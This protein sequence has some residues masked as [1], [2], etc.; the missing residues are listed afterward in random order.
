MDFVGPRVCVNKGKMKN[1]QKRKAH[2]AFSTLA[3]TKASFGLFSLVAP[4]TNIKLPEHQV[5]PNAT[6]TEQVMNRFHEVNKLYDGNLNK[7]H[8]L[9][10]ATVISTN[11][12]FMFRNAMKQD[13]KLDFVDATE[14][15]ISDH[16]RGKHWSIVHR[17]NLPNRARPTKSIW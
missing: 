2:T 12:I 17:D 11:E 1:S 5:N 10:Y 4:A 7:L 6:F 16:E 3:A 14:K 15:K 9:F 8:H 13:D